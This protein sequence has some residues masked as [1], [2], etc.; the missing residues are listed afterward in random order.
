MGNQNAIKYCNLW[1]YK[2]DLRAKIGKRK[3]KH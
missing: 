1:D 2:K 3:I